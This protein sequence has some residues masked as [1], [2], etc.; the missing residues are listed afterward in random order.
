MEFRE[1]LEAQF[2]ITTV[3]TVLIA[4]VILVMLF[5]KCH[6]VGRNWVPGTVI[7]RFNGREMSVEPECF[8]I[9]L[10][11]FRTP[12]QNIAPA[13]VLGKPLAPRHIEV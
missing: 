8:I 10:I 13:C 9:L 3:L 12:G 2:L 4:Y 6:H 11:G 1:S 5:C 7:V